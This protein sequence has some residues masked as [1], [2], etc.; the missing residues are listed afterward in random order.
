MSENNVAKWLDSGMH[1]GWSETIN[2]VVK[3]FAII[4][5]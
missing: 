3:E 5:G 1:E 2:R 4:G